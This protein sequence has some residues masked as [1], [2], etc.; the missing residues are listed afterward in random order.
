MAGP[1]IMRR[2]NSQAAL[3]DR[4][5]GRGSLSLAPRR[6]PLRERADAAMVVAS[7]SIGG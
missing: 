4:E 5:A 3:P 7:A 2:I 1:S 6:M